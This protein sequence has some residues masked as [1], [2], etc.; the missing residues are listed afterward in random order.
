MLG[1]RN[2]MWGSFAKIG[3]PLC[4]FRAATTQQLL[5]IA[6]RVSKRSR[7]NKSGLGIPKSFLLPSRNWFFAVL[8]SKSFLF[9]MGGWELYSLPS[10]G[11]SQEETAG[12][13]NS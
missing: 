3:R 9:G 8:R 10:S 11:E 7:S 4:V 13:K 2:S 1:T 6:D 12:A 5:P